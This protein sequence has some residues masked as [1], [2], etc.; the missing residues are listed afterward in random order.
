VKFIQPAVI[1]K[2]LDKMFENGCLQLLLI[3]IL[4]LSVANPAF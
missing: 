2:K 4:V 3:A 1:Y